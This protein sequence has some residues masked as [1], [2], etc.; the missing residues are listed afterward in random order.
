MNYYIITGASKGLGESFTKQLIDKNNH[1]FCIARS[2][3]N[4]LIEK[5]KKQNCALDY[6][7][8]D[9]VNSDGIVN[10][11]NEIFEKIDLEKAERI[12]LFNNAG[13]IEPIR[14][15]EKCS[16]AEMEKAIKINLVAP[17]AVTSA[18]LANTETVNSDKKVINISSGAAEEPSPSWSSYCTS[19]AGLNMFTRACGL[20][21]SSKE[22]PTINIAISPSIIDTGM[23]TLIR[24]IK[25]E[26]FADVEK[27]IQFKEEG[28]LRDPNFIAQKI[29]E[30]SQRTD[31]KQGG[32]YSVR[33]FL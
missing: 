10:L 16:A 12:Y 33:Q 24:G 26:D 11:M 13:V 18:F 4:E 27:F 29:L 21:Q 9:L 14:P 19:K 32:I 20:E 22:N 28:S 30:V 15:V 1:L 6:Y 8:Y 25:E 5:A 7:Q 3:N 17:M 31:L 23:Q 2:K